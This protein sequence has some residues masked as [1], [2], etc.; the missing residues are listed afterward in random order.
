MMYDDRAPVDAVIAE[1]ARLR[2]ENWQLKGALGYPV[3]GHIRESTEFK[4]GMCEAT[5]AE[6][7]LLRA[8]MK[9]STAIAWDL[10]KARAEIERLRERA[11]PE[12][13]VSVPIKPSERMIE[14]L[15]RIG[16]GPMISAA[17]VWGY[18]LAAAG[19]EE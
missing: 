10:G 5:N 19:A 2:T 8:M 14:E 3:P 1:I 7:E 18:M 11:V 9:G 12:G 16:D 13:H 6:N 17:E 4:C 15:A